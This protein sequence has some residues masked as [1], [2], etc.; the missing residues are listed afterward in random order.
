M[1]S[2]ACYNN[3]FKENNTKKKTLD[4]LQITIKNS[5]LQNCITNDNIQ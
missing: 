3:I 2:E 1:F 5:N 4:F